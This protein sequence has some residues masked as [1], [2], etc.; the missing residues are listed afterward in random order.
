MT[1]EKTAHEEVRGLTYLIFDVVEVMRG[2]FGSLAAEL[3]L[4]PLQ[5]RTILML[6]EPVPMRDLADRLA[7]DASNVTGLADR[8]EGLSA[9]ERVPGA[10]RRQKLL[11][12]TPEGRRLR[13]EL[14]ARTAEG[15]VLAERLDD[16]ERAALARGLTRPA[17]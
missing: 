4:T 15:S 16:R 2:S 6:E 13:A 11:S 8:L 10:D 7:C 9:I 17:R 1:T 14:E 3:G 5:A 12:L